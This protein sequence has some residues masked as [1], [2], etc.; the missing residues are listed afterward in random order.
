M[1]YGTEPGGYS[2]VG[3]TLHWLVALCVLTTIPVAL[4]MARIDSG[5]LQDRLYN[6]HQSLGVAIFVLMVLRLIYRLTAGAPA[7]E[8]TLNRMERAVSAAVHGLLYVLL[9]VMPILGYLANSA[10]GA[11]TPVFG[12][13]NIP[14]AIGQNEALSDRLFMLHRWIGYAVAGL[15]AAHIGAALQHF[16]LRR[17]GVLQRM[18]PRALGGT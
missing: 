2:G 1:T 10:Y 11:A 14:P 12:L 17:D 6:L 16:V 3:K 7:P 8:P 15:A 4:I 9:I 13:F 5:P 18:L